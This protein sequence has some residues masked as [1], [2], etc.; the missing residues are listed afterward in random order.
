[1]TNPA[2]KPEEILRLLSTACGYVRTLD[3]YQRFFTYYPE[4]G[5]LRRELY[6]KHMAFFEAGLDHRERLALCANGVGKTE[7]MGGYELT[8]HLCGL[9][10]D[11]WPGRRFKG[12]INAWAAGKTRETTRDIQQL[13]LLGPYNSMG[14]GLIPKKAL[15]KKTMQSGVSEAIDTMRVKHYPS[16]AAFHKDEHD[17]W[18]NLGFKAYKQG[19][20]SFEGTEKEVIWPD[21]EVPKPIYDEMILRTRTVDGLIMVTFTALQGVTEVVRHFLPHYHPDWEGDEVGE[22]QRLT[23]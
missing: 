3:N 14:T 15:G 5:P 22:Y 12:P 13:K 16:I 6:P 17:G 21:E 2:I 19:R 8:A 9:Y 1:M 23:A 7:G 10:P 20:D 18:S 11:W 4:T